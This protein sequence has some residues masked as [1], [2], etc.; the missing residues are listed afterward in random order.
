MATK[1][2]LKVVLT[3]EFIQD[4]KEGKHP[5]MAKQAFGHIFDDNG[6]FKSDR[7]DHEYRGIP[8]GWI[9]WVRLIYIRKAEVV[10]L[11]RI[12]GK[13]DEGGISA[14]ISFDQKAL[15]DDLPDELFSKFGESSESI[16]RRILTNARPV[17]LREAVRRMFHVP[18]SEIILISPTLS[19]PLFR[20]TGE[21]GRF[22]DKA[23]EEGASATLVTKPANPSEIGFFDDLA[24]RNIQVFFVQ[25]LQ[26][27]L[28]LF[29]VNEFRVGTK[30]GVERIGPTAVMGSAELTHHSLDIGDVGRNE[31]LC[32]SFSES[33]FDPFYSYAD[34]LVK[35]A[36]DLQGHKIKMKGIP[37]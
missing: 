9:R 7:Q 1:G 16:A 2:E 29:R 21:I 23:I 19:F 24:H 13:G 17:Y 10:Y 14:P 18:H 33:H 36:S 8:G 35:G 3:Q 37:R 11:Y 28:Y 20:T 30:T 22:L 4:I 27:R 25:N 34:E 6:N 26:S 12:V 32:Y 31:E 15:A 5:S